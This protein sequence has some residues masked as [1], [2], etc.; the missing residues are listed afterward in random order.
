MDPPIKAASLL[1]VRNLSVSV[2]SWKETKELIHRVSLSVHRNEVL[3]LLGE[4][5]SGKTV[6]SRSLTKLF[7]PTRPM[8]LEGSV[9]FEGRQLLSLDE[10]ELRPIRR[11]MIR[12]VFQ[13]PMQS[14]NPLANL[15][16]Q[17]HL[18][19]ESTSG[20]DSLLKDTLELVGLDAKQ[21]S[22]LF[23]HQLS[24]GM[25]QRVCIAM[26]VLP[27]P[28]LLIADEPTSAVDASLRYQLIDM[29]MSIQR[30]MAMSLILITH[31]LVLARS[32]GTRIAVLYGGRIIESAP[33]EAFFEKQLHPYSRLLVH[34]TQTPN[35]IVADQT[36]PPLPGG[37]IAESGC[38]FHLHCPIVRERCRESEPDLEQ[39]PGEREVRC[40]FWK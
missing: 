17:L 19:N 9:V 1:E 34:A 26:A 5:G 31:D 28:S 24:I 32:Y 36:P 16:T 38:R 14:L 25:A 3:V 12:Y 7:P 39:S 27:S 22:G 11:K 13:D 2:S 8:I 30:R 21:V 6:L 23:P 4:S 20:N 29:L 18:S 10:P 35:T 15:R 40:F 33:R 37:T